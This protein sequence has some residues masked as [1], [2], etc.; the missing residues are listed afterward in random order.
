VTPAG[1][2]HERE[3]LEAA[4]GGDEGAFRDLVE[5]YR[6]EL[7]A[8]CY[9]MLGSVH[10]AEDAVQDALL[11]AWRALPRFEPRH[12]LRAWLYKIATNVSID[13]IARRPKRVLPIDY[14]PSTDPHQTAREPVV[15]SVWVEPYPDDRLGVEDG[16]LGPE[17]RYE[18]R[19]GVELAFVA[20]LQHLPARQRAALILRE[21]LGFSAKETADA[22]DATPASVNSALQRARENV[23]QRLPEQT[24]QATL[25]SLGDERVRTIVERF[26]DAMQRDDIN[27]VVSMLAKDAAWSMPPL[28]SWYRGTDLPGF[29]RLGPL[30]GEWRWRHIPAHANG[31]AAFAAYE[32]ND[33]QQAY[34]P[35]ALNVLSFDGDK[36]SDVTSFLNRSIEG[37]DPEYY[38]R[39]P[40]QPLDAERTLAY[41]GRFGLPDRLE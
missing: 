22:L 16:Y 2:A 10:D 15:E 32:W 41:F 7:H 17:A 4:R 40:D 33:D 29:L 18:Q 21:V 24:Q 30:S 19:E 23:D 11:R 28:A 9:R 3:L 31:Q 26:M 6:T 37:T 5:P 35:F 13:A 20:C 39:F 14:G 34:L 12:S 25:R 36:I 1:T 27:A 8:H 38:A